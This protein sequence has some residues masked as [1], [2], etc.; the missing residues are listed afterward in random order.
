MGSVTMRLLPSDHKCRLRG[1]TL[2]QAIKDD[3]DKGLIPFYV[4]TYTMLSKEYQPIS[5]DLPL[6]LSGFFVRRTAKQ[7]TAKEWSINFHK[8]VEAT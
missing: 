8:Y 3:R 7:N 6:S 5:L 2:E 1:A 4:S